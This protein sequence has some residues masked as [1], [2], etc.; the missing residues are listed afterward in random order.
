MK[1][2]LFA[3]AITAWFLAV[4][5]WK[6]RPPGPHVA[7]QMFHDNRNRV[8]LFVQSGEELLAGELIHRS[9]A[10][11]FVIAEQRERIFKMGCGELKRHSLIF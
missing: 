7:A 3:V 11:S 9:F 4:A 8:H 10:Q 6:V 5:G 1:P 2:I